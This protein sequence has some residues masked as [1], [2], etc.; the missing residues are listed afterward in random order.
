MLPVSG[1]AQ[2][3]ASG[4]DLDAAPADLRQRRVL[5]VRQAR[6]PA[7]VG[8]EEIPQA[9]LTRLRL[10]LVDHRRQVVNAALGA[11]ARVDLLGRVDA[12]VHEGLE[13]R[14]H[15]QRALAVG[16][17]HRSSGLSWAGLASPSRALATGSIARGRGRGP[18]GTVPPQ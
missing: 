2:L 11:L 8:Q 10:Q 4:R 5:E 13:P 18:G 12:L 3:I 17:V 6:A 15:L 9:A 16:E 14:L 7:F 1:A